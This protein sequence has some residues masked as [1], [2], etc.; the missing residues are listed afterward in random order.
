L[1]IT[2]STASPLATNVAGVM[3]TFASVPNGWSGYGQIQLFG[4]PSLPLA[5]TSAKVSGG[6]LVMAGS[7]GTPGAGYTLLST[8]NLALPLSAWTTN[9]TGTFDGSGSFSNSIPIVPS[10]PASFF[11]V[12]IP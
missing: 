9:G 2:S 11:R 3:I 4:V 6:R 12:R 1:T 5:F 10:V 8:T 7:G